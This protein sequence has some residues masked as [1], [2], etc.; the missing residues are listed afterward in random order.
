MRQMTAVHIVVDPKGERQKGTQ[1]LNVSFHGQA[2]LE[3]LLLPAED[4][5][6]STIAPRAV[7]QAFQT[8]Q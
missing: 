3:K 2:P 4:F 1:G 5:A 7:E 6:A 8:H